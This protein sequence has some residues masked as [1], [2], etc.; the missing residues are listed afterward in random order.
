MIAVWRDWVLENNIKNI[1]PKKVFSFFSE[2]CSIPHGSGNLDGIVEYLVKFA[3]D[4]NLEYIKDNANNVIIK[5]SA[6]KGMP[7]ILQAHTDM[8]CVS[9]PNLDIDMKREAISAY[10]NGNLLKAKGTSLGAD[11]GIG[12]ALILAILD[13]N[14]NNYPPIEAFF[15]SDEE[16]GMNGAIY[17]DG[18]KFSAKR[19]INIDSED[20]GVLTVSCCGGSHI[21]IE[22]DVERLDFDSIS[23]EEVIIS[24]G[25]SSHTANATKY[26][27]FEIKISGLLG[28][29]SGMEIHKGRANAIVEMAYVL[30]ELSNNKIDYYLSSIN[31]G[32][33]ENVICSNCVSNVYV[34]IK[35]LNKFN[36]L[37][38]KLDKDLKKEYILSDKNIKLGAKEKEDYNELQNAKS[39]ETF[40]FKPIRTETTKKLIDTIISLPNG[41]I[42]ISQEFV[43][44]P[45]TSLNQG[46][47][48]TD[49]KKIK[50][51][52]F[53]RSNDDIKRKK[54]VEKIKKIISNAGGNIYISGE[55]PAWQY[56]KDSKLKEEILKTYKELYGKDM[57]VTATHGGLECG[58]LMQKIEGLDAVSIGPTVENVHSV[59]ET[60]HIDTVC[61]IYDLLKKFLIAD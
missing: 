35:D 33:F 29:H 38:L 50:I 58:L 22:F 17:V 11:D 59:D 7:I 31:G 36:D 52:I 45:W 25:K 44:L 54:L 2:I 23:N 28:G 27:L 34:N 60:L 61:K 9:E 42:E 1:E 21:E 48:E 18:S 13:D 57:E 14:E 3:K 8:V 12:V 10:V 39:N 4:R 16:T 24:N 6:T 40:A 37:I 56:Q 41:L 20:E 51:V 55:Y 5:K 43:N 47:I 26:K 15:T 53:V 46:V 32:R 19:L 49:G 30:N